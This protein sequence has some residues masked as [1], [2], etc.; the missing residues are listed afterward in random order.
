MDNIILC[1][2]CLQCHCHLSI[3]EGFKKNKNGWINPS[4]LAGW[5]QP[6]S[7]IQPKKIAETA[8]NNLTNDLEQK[9][10]T[11]K[12]NLPPS[13]PSSL[14]NPFLDKTLSPQKK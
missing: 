7:K 12:N 6:G 9:K 10:F 2:T 8:S 5:G 14:P 13:P 4:G 11:Q 1:K 3:R